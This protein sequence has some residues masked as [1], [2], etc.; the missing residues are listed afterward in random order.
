MKKHSRCDIIAHNYNQHA[1]EYDVMSRKAIPWL[2]FDMPFLKM[3]VIPSVSRKT[4]LLELGSGGGK[5]L[6]LFKVKIPE[7][8]LTGIDVSSELIAIA[9]TKLPQ[10]TFTLGDFTKVYLPPNHFD[11]VLSVRSIE[12]LNEGALRKTFR[13]VYSTLKNGG[14]FFVV[15]GHPIRVNNGHISTYLERGPRTVSLPWGMKVDLYHKTTSDIL[16]AALRA[17]FTLKAINEVGIPFS[18]KKQDTQSYTTYKSHGVT[19][20][21]VI[22]SK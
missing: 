14:V 19:S 16:N 11:V 5:V 4:K 6:E 18:L 9:T 1:A 2:C 21:Q 3:N 12:Y 13:S 7:K 20:L 17:G 8:K 10:A 22:L 15:T